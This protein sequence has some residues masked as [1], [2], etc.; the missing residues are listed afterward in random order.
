MNTIYL[1]K[2]YI[3]MLLFA[4]RR[5]TFSVSD[6]H[7]LLFLILAPL[8]YVCKFKGVLKSPIGYLYVGNSTILRSSTYGI[9]K[10]YFSYMYIL[11]KLHLLNSFFSTIVDV[12]AN[13]GDF[14]LAIRKF[15]E[16]VVSIEPD[17]ENVRAL[18][19]NLSLNDPDN[20]I[21][22]KVA[23]HN[24]EETLYLR[25]ESSNKYV[26]QVQKGIEVPV[27]GM[28]LDKIISSL[29]IEN[30]DVLKIDVQGHEEKVI[31]GARSLF[32]DNKVKILIVEAHVNRGV[33]VKNIINSLFSYGYDLIYEEQ[34]LIKE[35]PHL[36]FKRIS[37]DN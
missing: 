35:Q 7:A 31:D 14:T 20:I 3:R 25:G 1:L 32:R 5:V 11:R 34:Y 33:S 22:L 15:A 26:V 23:A 19:V 10:T 17:E 37:L 36:Y 30:I 13:V 16:R 29:K 9:F 28:P 2:V 8:F 12:G 21:V 24:K 6:L 4:L 18:K 27:K